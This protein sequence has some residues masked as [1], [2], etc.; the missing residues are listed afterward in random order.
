MKLYLYKYL[1]NSFSPQ[2]QDESISSAKYQTLQ[3]ERCVFAPPPRIFRK[4]G[5]SIRAAKELARENVVIYA[6]ETFLGR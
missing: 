2:F 1:Y 5:K 3:R 4:R 6:E